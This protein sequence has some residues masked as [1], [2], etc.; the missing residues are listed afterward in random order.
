MAEFY[1]KKYFLENYKIS[2][3]R[4]LLI[5][6]HDISIS[7]STLKRILST[8]GLKRKY[9]QES[10][11]RDIIAAAIEEV[12]SCGYN[13]GYRSL[14]KKLKLQYKLRVRKETVYKI[15]KILDPEGIANRYGNKLRR[16]RYISPGPNFMWHLDG[17]DK[18][19]QF[20]FA[21]YGCIDGF[22][23]KVMWLEVATTN[24]YPAGTSVKNQRIES[25]WGQMRQHTVDFYIQLF[26]C[27]QEKGL[28]DGSSLHIK[29]LQL[30]F[31]PLL[32][33]DLQNNKKLWNQHRIRRQAARNH[34]DTV[35]KL[36]ERFTKKPQLFDPLMKE[37]TKLLI[38]DFKIPT[39]PTEAFNLYKQILSEYAA[40]KRQQ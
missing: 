21:I 35:G 2:D 28:F 14:W 12:N 27:M 33:Y 26:K 24:N 18:L 38:P 15:L 8:L 22:S 7:M 16:R 20:G 25:Y 23:R 6:K 37:L 31:G 32:K 10:N 9:V 40:F 11:M 3:I 36:I 5:T 4:Q 34:L 13:L 19:K 39:N 30:C 1:I 17:Y 29:C